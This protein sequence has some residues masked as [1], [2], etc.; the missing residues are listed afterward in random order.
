MTSVLRA[1]AAGQR[2]EAGPRCARH[3]VHRQHPRG[4]ARPHRDGPQTLRAVR[5]RRLGMAARAADRHG[6]GPRGRPGRPGQPGQ[7]VRQRT[8]LGAT[9]SGRSSTAA[10]CS[11]TSRSTSTTAASCR[12][13]SPAAAPVVHG[14]DGAASIASRLP[15]VAARRGSRLL[16]RRQAAHSRPRRW[17][18]SWASSWRGR[19]R[20]T[21]RSST[22][23]GRARSSATGPRRLRWHRGLQGRAGARG[24]LPR[25]LPAKRAHGGDDLFAALCQAE[26]EDGQRFT[27][28]D[29][30]NHMIFA[31]MA[32][33][34]TT[35]ITLTTMAYYLAKNPEWQERAR[36][37]TPSAGRDRL[38]RPATTRR[39]STS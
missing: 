13:R 11:W 24:V 32:A 28:E 2:T 26:T 34:D 14:G 29:V 5:P 1:A 17:T 23:S 19:T 31:M 10:S 15:T 9:S 8:R 25:H 27:D 22:R 16:R 30:V 4:D 21:A 18:S 33:H 39:R 36:G 6:P 3:P 38:R 20:S 12:R 7:G 37:V 35:T